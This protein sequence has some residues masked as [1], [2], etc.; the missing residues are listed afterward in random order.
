MKPIYWVLLIAGLSSIP[1]ILIFILIIIFEITWWALLI[2]FVIEMV[3]GM[4]IGA[5][6]LWIKLSKRPKEKLTIDPEDAE[7]RA[8]HML[9]Y[10]LEHPDNF[11]RKNRVIE[12]VGEP[13]KERTKVLWLR[14]EVSETMQKADILINLNNPNL[15]P[16]YIFGNSDEEVKKIIRGYAD[17]PAME[18]TREIITEPNELGQPITKV[19][20]TKISREE[21]KEK[22]EI[23]K[24]TEVNAF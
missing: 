13:G 5:I 24:A 10:D 19:R 8:I 17:N 21:K 15:Y 18:E 14:G 7:E 1:M 3:L 20:T 9:K 23:E 12:N 22:E 6:W 11:K 2:T 16:I 4:I